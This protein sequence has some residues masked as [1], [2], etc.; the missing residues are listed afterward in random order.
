[1]TTDDADTPTTDSNVST[2]PD[3]TRLVAQVHGA[4]LRLSGR[5]YRVQL[6]LLPYS[7]LLELLRFTRDVEYGR[8]AAVRRARSEP[9]RR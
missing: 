3:T 6:E 5:V 1:M 9:W 8:D 4:M 2:E 7:S